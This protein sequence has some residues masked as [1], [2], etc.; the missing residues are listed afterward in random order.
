[1]NEQQRQASRTRHRRIH[2]EWKT[3]G[4]TVRK[5]V[6]DTPLGI[7]ACLIATYGDAM[8]LGEATRRALDFRNT[9]WAIERGG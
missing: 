9:E 1:M 4:G 3:K 7:V 2:E 6:Y 8:T 5:R